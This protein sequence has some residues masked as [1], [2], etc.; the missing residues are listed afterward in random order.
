M[1]HLILAALVCGTLGLPQ[2]PPDA[3]TVA[4]DSVRSVLLIQG[5]PAGYQL[6]WT[7]EDG[8][9]HVH[10]EFND[11]GRGASLDARFEVDAAGL[12]TRLETA[13]NDYLKAPVEETF[14]LADGV[15]SWKNQAEE[16]EQRVDTGAFYLS[17][18]GVPEEY[19]ML[20]RAL[21]NAPGHRLALLPVGE[22]RIEQVGALTLEL[23]GVTKTVTQ[24]VITG[25]GFTP[26]PI[27]LDENRNYFATAGLWSAI[28]VEGWEAALPAL[29]E[30][31]EQE[32]NAR[33]RRMAEELAQRPTGPVA[34]VGA[35]LFDAQTGAV[36]GGTTV[37]VS[38]DRIQAVGPDGS[39]DVP[40]GARVIEAGGRMLLPGLIDMHTHVSDVDGL[41]HIA[42]GVTTVRDLANDTEELLARKQRWDD[43]SAIGPRV[44][45]AGFMD[46]P[47][48]YAG[49]TRVLVDTPDEVT[50]AVDEYA[51]LGY[52]QIK[53]YSSIIP[54]LVPAIVARARAHGMRVSGHIPAFTT[55][56]A[57]VRQGLDEIQHVNMLFL[58]FLGD[59]LDTRTPL[60]FTAVAEHAAD[61]DLGSDS[62]AAFIRLL[63]DQN[64]VVDPTVAVFEGLLEGRAGAIAPNAAPIADRLPPV[65]RRGYLG[66]GLP[67]PDG[68]DARYDAAFDAML[69]MVKVLYDA[70]VTLVAGTDA[71]AGFMLHRELEDYVRAGIPP[72]EVLRIATSGAAEVAGR[73]DRLGQVAPN[74]LA[75]LILVDGDPTAEISDIRKVDLVMKNGVLFDPAAIYRAIGVRPWRRPMVAPR[76]D[77]P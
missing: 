71:L 58:N 62:V 70:G 52:E 28:V 37:L 56:E 13:G 18:N 33:L 74:M 14:R 49:P 4:T 11:R 30:A 17:M 59:T 64:V 6:V 69:N 10:F 54:E 25:L 45:M 2:E 9:L 43:V 16:G 5:T 26:E 42:A 1:S 48:P 73:A 38:G 8:A 27:W 65:V 23:G 66:G 19:A 61:L 3:G 12:L 75:D 55:A 7:D 68:M 36:R 44:I 57:A 15:A 46:G 29:S 40:T 51:R 53:I 31:S 47:G 72:A 41:L 35:R 34:I 50:A 21:L 20:A 32:A 39:V 77:E 24:Y 60:R 67:V 76:D 22:A 63:K